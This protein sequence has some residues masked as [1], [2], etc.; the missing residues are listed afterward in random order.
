MAKKTTKKQYTPFEK[1]AILAEYIETL[2]QN[3]YFINDALGRPLSYFDYELVIR[4][5]DELK[6]EYDMEPTDWN[7]V[8]TQK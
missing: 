6:K 5:T 8:L 2:V 1:R 4:R 3:G 7:E